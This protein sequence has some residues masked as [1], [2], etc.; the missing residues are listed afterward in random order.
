MATPVTLLLVA[1]AIILGAWYM[2]VMLWEDRV[3]WYDSGALGFSWVAGACVAFIAP[4]NT[5][6]RRVAPAAAARAALPPV[7]AP[8]AWGAFAASA[9]ALFGIG[10]YVAN[11]VAAIMWPSDASTALAQRLA[12]AIWVDE[13]ALAIFVLVLLAATLALHLTTMAYFAL[14]LRRAAGTGAPQRV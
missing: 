4:V 6:L 9:L 14:V 5:A 2:G 1:H 11:L 13:Q 10:R 8:L 12:A 3:V 7:P